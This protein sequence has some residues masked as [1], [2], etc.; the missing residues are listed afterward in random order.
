MTAHSLTRRPFLGLML[1]APFAARAADGLAAILAPGAQVRT[2]YADGEWCEGP[3]WVPALNS[4]VFSDVRRNR[5]IRIPDGG[6]PVTFRDPS[7]NANGNT[8]DAQ[9]R[10]ITCQ[11]RTGRVVRQE[12]DGTFTVLAE[13][14]RG[15]RLNSPNDAV[16]AG[17]GAIWFTDPTYGI[18]QGSEG[19]PRAS[20]QAGSF[21]YRRAPDGTLAAVATDFHQPNG[22]S[23]S[24]DGRVLYVAESGGAPDGAMP[25]TI[26]AFDV[27]GGRLSNGRVFAR[28]EAGVPDGLKTDT[29]GRLYAGTGDGVRVWSPDGTFLGRIPTEGPCANIAFGGPDGRRLYICAGPKV[30]AV[31]TRVRGARVPA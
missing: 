23:F 25:R 27:A 11:H 7:D 28:L 8:L 3:V 20:E 19:E 21:V 12:P 31:E 30:L 29:D 13:R 16:V 4:L 14:F 17:D 5:M 10:L 26:R 15:G 2:L 9:G 24:P 22:L 18:T 6:A 1:L